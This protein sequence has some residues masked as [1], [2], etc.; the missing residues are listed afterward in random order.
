[1]FRTAGTSAT[2][3]SSRLQRY[4]RDMAMVRTHRAAQFQSGAEEFGRG[5][6]EDL[7]S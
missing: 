3:A 1:M 2:R 5:Y 4:Y 7:P 6:F